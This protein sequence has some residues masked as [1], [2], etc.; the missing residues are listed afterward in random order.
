MDRLAR[1]VGHA[2]GALPGFALQP[3]RLLMD[4]LGARADY[5]GYT[6]A[7]TLA[8]IEAQELLAESAEFF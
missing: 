5:P 4:V 2:V 8:K 1:D 7:N 3:Q 6:L